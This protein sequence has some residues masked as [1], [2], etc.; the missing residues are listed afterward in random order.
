VNKYEGLQGE[1][2]RV[3]L[4]SLSNPSELRNVIT[5]SLSIWARV[6]PKETG[7]RIREVDHHEDATEMISALKKRFAKEMA[8]T[9]IVDS[10]KAAARTPRGK[11]V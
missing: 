4:E 7:L 11:K 6:F 8:D 10:I 2:R 9:D 5:G 1:S 3:F